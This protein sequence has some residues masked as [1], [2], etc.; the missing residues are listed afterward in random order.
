MK[1][2]PKNDNSENCVIYLNGRNF[3][4]L[5]LTGYLVKKIVDIFGNYQNSVLRFFFVNDEFKT[6]FG[7]EF[8]STFNKEIF[9][10]F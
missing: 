10:R 4:G 7:G 3:R 6:N 1:C 9:K 5:G 8:R 2:I